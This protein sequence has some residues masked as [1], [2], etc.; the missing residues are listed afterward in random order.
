MTTYADQPE[1]RA[2]IQAEAERLKAAIA[3]GREPAES[4]TYFAQEAAKA[5]R[6]GYAL[7]HNLPAPKWSADAALVPDEP[8]LG[9]DI[10]AVP[11]LGFPAEAREHAKRKGDGDR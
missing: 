5:E 6:E 7:S 11:D 8:K 3:K 4:T 10:N 2:I 1:R 9:E